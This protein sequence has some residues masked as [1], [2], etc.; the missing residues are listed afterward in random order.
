[1]FYHNN[2][3]QIKYPFLVTWKYT[4]TLLGLVSKQDTRLGSGEQNRTQASYCP[5]GLTG[6]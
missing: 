1:M 4:E 6:Y 2:K 3:Q 5:G